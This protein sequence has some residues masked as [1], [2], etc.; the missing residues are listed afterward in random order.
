MYGCVEVIGM[1][2]DPTSYR[3]GKESQ[4][5]V[6]Q[7]ASII[8]VSSLCDVLKGLLEEDPPLELA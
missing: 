6:Y 4:L 2:D 1:D 5:L 3:C 8:F 7:I